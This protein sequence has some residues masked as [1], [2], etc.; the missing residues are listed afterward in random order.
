M[1]PAETVAPADNQTALDWGCAV[2]VWPEKP[3]DDPELFAELIERFNREHAA[4]VIG[5]STRY[6]RIGSD[7][8]GYRTVE[9]WTAQG[10]REY[11]RGVIVQRT[12]KRVIT[13]FGFWAESPDRR[14]YTGVE[15]APGSEVNPPKLK[16]AGAFNLWSGFGVTPAQGD[17][18]LF[19]KHLHDG[20]CDGDTENFEWLMDWL[21]QRIQSPQV[22]PST[23][24]ALRS[25]AR[26]VGK[27]KLGS[28]MSRIFGQHAVKISDKAQL[29]GKFNAHQAFAVFCYCEEITFA[30]SP[31][32][33][34]RLRDLITAEEGMLE[35]KGMDAV[36]INNFTSFLFN[37]N[38]D[39]V[40]AVDL[41]ER[42]YFVLDVKWN[43][44]DRDAKIAYFDPILRQM[45]HEGGIEA[46]MHELTYRK[47]TRNLIIAPKTE[48]LREQEEH[49]LPPHVRLLAEIARTE[50]VPKLE[51]NI[52]G[53]GH[54]LGQFTITKV[55]S[56]ALFAALEVDAHEGRPG[57]YKIALGQLMKRLKIKKERDGTAGRLEYY[58][59]PP[60]PEFRSRLVDV[61][62]IDPHLIEPLGCASEAVIGGG[63]VRS[64]GVVVA[65]SDSKRRVKRRSEKT[66]PTVETLQ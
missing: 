35:K 2:P 48:A 20:I 39:H 50:I 44:R 19:R 58:C 64:S 66:V 16:K 54:V 11:Y 30:G 27:S 45:E 55:P 9:F 59:F 38:E 42:R 5:T 12:G 28:Y 21:A 47:I 40:I 25:K 37:S 8:R 31:T 65:L 51:E 10:L 3:S 61:L 56:K 62:E 52:Y 57:A 17:W 46:M 24:V 60:A 26:G 4:V 22:K 34:T 29:L 6:L 18:S 33:K 53:R 49:G 63:Q 36:P 32:E 7:T 15:F 43:I 1:S 13:A 23:A 41:Q 14:H